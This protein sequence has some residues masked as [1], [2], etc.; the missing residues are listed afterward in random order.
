MSL[1]LWAAL[2]ASLAAC[3]GGESALDP[4]VA[5]GNAAQIRAELDTSVAGKTTAT[6]ADPFAAQALAAINAARAA[7]A[8]CGDQDMPA[9]PPVQWNAQVAYAALLQS[10]WMQQA[11][12]FSHA[13]P[14][15]TRVGKRL[16][17]AGAN[18]YLADENI[19]A[20]FGSIDEAIVGW[21]ASP[22]HC[23][24]LMR[25]ELTEAGMAVVPGQPE[26]SYASYWT[27]VLVR[28]PGG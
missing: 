24:A 13:W 12:A 14:D 23:S 9:A 15:G 1:L 5:T 2:S 22:S 27:M 28:P 25:A 21:L 19:A 11:N 4:M 17:M 6:P 20:G 18:W 7:G 26:N 16:D 3:G 10:E 8:R